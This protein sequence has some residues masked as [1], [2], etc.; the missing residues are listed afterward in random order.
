MGAVD[1]VKT[2]LLLV[3]GYFFGRAILHS[4]GYLP[5]YA[6]AVIVVLPLVHY[7]NYRRRKK[8]LPG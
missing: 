6:I 5:Y 2:T 4:R 8:S 1:A 3:L 7:L